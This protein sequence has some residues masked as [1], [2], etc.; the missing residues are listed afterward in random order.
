MHD[1]MTNAWFYQL[2]AANRLLIKKNG[3]IEAAA[4]T[5]SLSKSQVGRC[6]NDGDTE[7]LPIPAVLRLEA[8]CGDPCVTRV[9][10]GLHGCKLTDP[11]KENRDGTCLLRGSLELGAVANEYQRNASVRFSD[12]KV[13]PTEAGQGIRELQALI[14]KASEQIRRYSEILAK[15]GSEMPDLKIVGGE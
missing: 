2:K 4:D 6:N 14:D 8:E 12:L 9:M 1:T 3:G 13:T 15:G 7:L 10:A 5:C 11:E